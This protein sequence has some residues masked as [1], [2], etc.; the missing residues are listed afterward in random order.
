MWPDLHF[1]RTALA[2]VWGI[3]CQ[4]RRPNA[5]RQDKN[6]VQQSGERWWGITYHFPTLICLARLLFKKAVVLSCIRGFLAGVSLTSGSRSSHCQ[7]PPIVWLRLLASGLTSATPCIRTWHQVQDFSSCRSPGLS[8]LAG[9]LTCCFVFLQHLN[10]LES[11]LPHCL[12]LPSGTQAVCLQAG[13]SHSLGFIPLLLRTPATSPHTRAL[14]WLPWPVCFLS[15]VCSACSTFHARFYHVQKN[16]FPNTCCCILPGISY[17]AAND[18]AENL[19][20]KTKSNSTWSFFFSRGFPGLLYTSSGIPWA[21]WFRFSQN[22]C[23]GW[24]LEINRHK[25]DYPYTSSS[26]SL[27]P[28]LRDAI[29]Y[30]YLYEERN[31]GGVKASQKT[32]PGLELL[33]R[34]WFSSSVALMTPISFLSCGLKALPSQGYST[35][36]S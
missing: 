13:S 14:P 2:A 21:K 16:S 10:S 15:P 25:N 8:L 3:D 22:F 27:L 9:S 33:R 11:S 4:K 6:L 34:I 1:R 30:F 17:V 5:G 7:E 24:N 32:R 28:L 26:P 31:K 23:P 18:W 36:S 19:T 20:T 29:L 12:A 35:L